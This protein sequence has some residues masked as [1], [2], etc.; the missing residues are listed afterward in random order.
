MEEQ[1]MI[2]LQGSEA[3]TLQE[4]VGNIDLHIR[5]EFEAR[6]TAWQ[7]TWMAPHTAHLSDPSFV[8]YNQEFL[9]LIELGEQIVPLLIE[10]LLDPENFFVLQV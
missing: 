4:A 2:Q 8:Q 9:A 6:F 1:D 3:T 10:K 7:Y 5:Q